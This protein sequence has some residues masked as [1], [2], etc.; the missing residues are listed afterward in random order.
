M[1]LSVIPTIGPPTLPSTPPPHQAI[2]D[3]GSTSHFCTIRA[4]VINKRPANPPIGIENA[5]GSIMY[6]THEAE[7]DIPNLPLAARHVHIVP[8]LSNFSLIS[9]GQLCDS[10][11]SV[12]FDRNM[13][14][15]SHNNQVVLSGDRARSTGLW[16]MNLFFQLRLRL[17]P[18]P[19]PPQLPHRSSLRSHKNV[20]LQWLRFYLIPKILSPL[21][22]GLITP[23]SPPLH[24][25]LTS[26]LLLPLVP[27][28][29]P[30]WS[31]SR[32]LH[33]FRPR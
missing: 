14:T 7:L 30:N 21:R 2:A 22:L 20:M 32:M 1:C 29:P 13:V 28:A 31:R 8:E 19:Q 5:N 27:Q 25:L 12:I 9:I 10:D 33:S 15:V 11:C 26:I 17:I 23:S 18:F 4:P 24:Q 6:S 3:S 16:H